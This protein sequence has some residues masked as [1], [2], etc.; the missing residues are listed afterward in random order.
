[1]KTRPK[2]AHR[3]ASDITAVLRTVYGADRFPVDVKTVAREISHQKYPDDPI[4]MIRGKELPGFEGALVPAPPGKTGWGILYNKAIDSSGRINFTLGHELGHY[5]LHRLDYPQGFQCTSED[6]SNWDSEYGQLEQQANTF[7]AD[8]LMP[9]DDFRCQIGVWDRPALNDVGDCATRYDVSLTAALLRW[10]EYTSRSS[11]LVVSTDGFILWA[12]SSKSA[13]KC[14]LY[15]KTRNLPPIEVP[16]ASLAGQRS[17][18][19]G[20]AAETEHDHEVW[21]GTRCKE[22]VLFSDRY[23]FT[24]SLIHFDDRTIRPEQEEAPEEDAYD[25]MISRNIGQSWLG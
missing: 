5:L 12:R 11:V 4:T 14:G 3:W 1:M 7:A 16:D 13:L 8:L 22:Y 2:S 25:R 20:Y 15:Y 18:V 9:F 21:L 6:M 10:L 24:L 19:A 17:Q 23:D